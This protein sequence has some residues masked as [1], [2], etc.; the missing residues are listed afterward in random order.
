MTH[1]MTAPSEE[2]AAVVRWLRGD[3]GVIPALAAFASLVGGNPMPDMSGDARNRLNKFQRREFDAVVA[4]ICAA[5][6][7]GE[8]IRKDEGHE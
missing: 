7:R 1:P 6:E 2:R 3:G 4:R 5:I 8:H